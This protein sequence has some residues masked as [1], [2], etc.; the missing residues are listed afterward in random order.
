MGAK[1]QVQ[2]VNCHLNGNTKVTPDSGASRYG[3]FPRA[4]SGG[5]LFAPFTL[6]SPRP[7]NILSFQHVDARPVG[8]QSSPS[9]HS[10]RRLPHLCGGTLGGITMSSRNKSG[11]T[12]AF[13]R[14]ISKPGKYYD[15][16]GL[17][18]RVAPSGRRYWEQRLTFNGRRRHLGIGPC[19]Q[20]SLKEARARALKSLA[21]VADGGDPFLSP[22]SRS[23]PTFA[24]L[25]REVLVRRS[26]KWTSDTVLP[27]WQR[28]FEAPRVP[29]HWRHARHRYP[30][31]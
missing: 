6:R 28:T 9:V 14:R 15:L 5:A 16:H 22:R 11:L 31:P 8:D 23:I 1:S 3:K 4:G 17:C 19:P 21:L 24:E 27:S 10:V 26:A 13:V 2:G 18:L 25:A 30:S 7:R 20:L 12:A 29:V